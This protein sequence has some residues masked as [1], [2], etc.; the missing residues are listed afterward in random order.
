MDQSPHYSYPHDISLHG[1]DST[2]EIVALLGHVSKDLMILEPHINCKNKIVK[3]GK[4]LLTA[5]NGWVSLKEENASLFSPQI[6]HR[7]KHQNCSPYGKVRIPHW[8]FIQWP[9]KLA[10]FL[11]IKHNQ[12]RFVK[13]FDI[14]FLILHWCSILDF[15]KYTSGI[16]QV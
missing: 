15:I 5:I 6:P 8:L 3:T 13:N 11:Y 16:F 2:W 7:R 1:C 14:R 10:L 9:W 12:I 4:L